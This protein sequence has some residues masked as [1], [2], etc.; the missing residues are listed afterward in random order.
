MKA[1]FR[2]FYINQGLERLPARAE[3][4]APKIGVTPRSIDV[5]ELGYRWASCS[6]SGDLAFH[7]KC[8]MAL[9]S[10]IDYVVVHELCHLHHRDHTDAFW[11]EVDKM[12][13]DYHERKEW[14]R[15]HGAGLDV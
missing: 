3:Y 5:T 14:L 12:M 8:M 4:Y 13:P 11:N 10:I 15:R 7:W 1:A 9:P 2:Q 6:P